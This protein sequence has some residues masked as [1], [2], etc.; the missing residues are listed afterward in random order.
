[1][2]FELTTMQDIKTMKQW[3]E[4]L[5][6][7]FESLKQFLVPVS[8]TAQCLECPNGCLRYIIH[9]LAPEIWA[10][11]QKDPRECEPVQLNQEDIELYKLEI[12]H[13]F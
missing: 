4:K 2:A 13:G 1:M 11:C 7:T 10:I 3:Q 8:E 9:D 6:K 5:G 12:Q